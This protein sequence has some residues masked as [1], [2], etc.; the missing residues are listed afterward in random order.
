MGVGILGVLPSGFNVEKLRVGHFEMDYTNS[1]D[2][3]KRQ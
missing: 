3:N 2:A 1:N